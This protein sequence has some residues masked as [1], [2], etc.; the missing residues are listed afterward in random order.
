MDS[1]IKK[2]FLGNIDEEVR[3]QFLRFGKGNYRRRFLIKF[4][5]TKKIKLRAS[6]E[7]A[8]DFVSFINEDKELEFSGKI[9]SKTKI[10]GKVG[11]KKSGG[12]VYNISNESINGFEEA[13][14]FLLDSDNEDALLKIKKK[15][16]KPGK[17]V[18]KIDDKFCALDLDFDYWDK[19]KEV[20]F[21]DIPDGKKVTI[22]HEVI[23]NDIEIPKDEPDPVKMREKAIRKGKIIR[24]INVDGK[25]II[26]EVE[27]SA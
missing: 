6:F 13:Y 7:Y 8:N 25:E 1:F 15:L 23:I 2:I 9:L 26:K 27:F 5:K 19:L 4:N 17:S 20:F 3:G 22:E 21:W 11:K 12:F 10:E 16:P 18:K 14:Y 24:T